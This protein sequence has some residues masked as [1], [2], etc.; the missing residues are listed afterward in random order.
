MGLKI[1]SG[2]TVLVLTGKDRGKKGKVERV[3]PRQQRLVVEGV[4]LVK[5][6]QRP[7]QQ[8]MQGGIVEQAAPLHISNVMLVCRRCD[9]PTR[10]GKKELQDGSFVRA[11]K[12]CGETIDG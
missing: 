2:D 8:M 12:R 1:R 4:N 7:T 3:L 9:K 10:V 11:C 5:K 6:H